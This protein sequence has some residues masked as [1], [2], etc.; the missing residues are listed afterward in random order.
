MV[1]NTAF[2]G[3]TASTVIDCLMQAFRPQRNL[4]WHRLSQVSLIFYRGRSL[5]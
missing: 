1:Q 2:S 5:F 4:P 3:I